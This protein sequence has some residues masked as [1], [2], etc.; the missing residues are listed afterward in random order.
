M[1]AKPEPEIHDY[2]DTSTLSNNC[3][4]LYHSY[5]KWKVLELFIYSIQS[6][7]NSTKFLYNFLLKLISS[8]SLCLV[9]L[10]ATEEISQGIL[11]ST[12]ALQLTNSQ[13]FHR[14]GDQIYL[15]SPKCKKYQFCILEKIKCNI[16]L[17][18]DI[19]LHEYTWYMNE[20]DDHEDM[21]PMWWLMR[22]DAVR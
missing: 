3:N 14:N 13:L 8:H 5:N 2:I 15:S 18:F 11:P 12:L 6:A 9:F 1:S 20:P 4:D 21:W 7:L 17:I 19:S 10:V 22:R 16:Y